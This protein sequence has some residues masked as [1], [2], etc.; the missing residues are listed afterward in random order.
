MHSNSWPGHALWYNNDTNNIGIIKHFLIG[1]KSCFTSWNPWL[2]QLMGQKLIARQVIGPKRKHITFLVLNEHSIKM[3]S[4]NL[5]YP[6]IN[7]SVNPLVPRFYLQ[8]M[9]IYSETHNI[10]IQRIKGCMTILFLK[11][12]VSV[13]SPLLNVQK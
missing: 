2:A 5:L 1:F 13:T 6:C 11:Q 10:W 12:D 8:L 7:I 4:N 9:V 3:T